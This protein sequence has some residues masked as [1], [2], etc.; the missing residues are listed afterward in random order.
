LGRVDAI[1]LMTGTGPSM[2]WRY[3]ETALA[4]LTAY[5]DGEPDP[6]PYLRDE[7]N[8][9]GYAPRGRA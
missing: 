6:L 3:L 4:T 7:L 2:I 8:T 9:Q 1:R 5:H